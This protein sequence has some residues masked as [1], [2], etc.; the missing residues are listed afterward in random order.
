MQD[1]QQHDH[2]ARVSLVP[3][4]ASQDVS[5]CHPPTNPGEVHQPMTFV[6]APELR[7]SRLNLVTC[8]NLLMNGLQPKHLGR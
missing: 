2:Q 1:D 6:D 5:E 7:R 8:K 4:R 3:E